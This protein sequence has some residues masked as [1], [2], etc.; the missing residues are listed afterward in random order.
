MWQRKKNPINFPP[1]KPTQ[2]QATVTHPTVIQGT[3]VSHVQC[4]WSSQGQGKGEQQLPK[5]ALRIPASWGDLIQGLNHM[6][7]MN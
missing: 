6:K 2:Q 7:Y 3:S 1:L 5:S 4:L